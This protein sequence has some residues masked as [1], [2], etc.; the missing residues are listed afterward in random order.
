MMIAT[1]DFEDK[2]LFLLKGNSL[3]NGNEAKGVI[4]EPAHQVL[5]RWD[6]TKVSWNDAT[7]FCK[8]FILENSTIGRGSSTGLKR[9][10]AF[11]WSSLL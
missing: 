8:K 4:Y 7:K 9:I 5:V 3:T 11:L 1:K 2:Y 10:G 6:E